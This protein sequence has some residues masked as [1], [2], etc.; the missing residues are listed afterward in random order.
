M[1]LARDRESIAAAGCE[2][3]RQAQAV[4]AGHRIDKN[5]GLRFINVSAQQS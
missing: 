3:I 4:L 2:S 1:Q 5:T